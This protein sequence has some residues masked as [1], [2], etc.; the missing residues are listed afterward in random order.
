MSKPKP[1]LGKGLVR[2][3][4]QTT[5]SHSSISGQSAP[6][7][8]QL[9]P[10]VSHHPQSQLYST[11]T[12]EVSP[13]FPLPSYSTPSHSLSPIVSRAGPSTWSLPAA[14]SGLVIQP[15]PYLSLLPTWD[16][17]SSEASSSRH[18][19]NSNPIIQP[20]RLSPSLKALRTPKPTRVHRA[21][22]TTSSAPARA[23]VEMSSMSIFSSSFLGPLPPGPSLPPSLLS[24][25]IQT[26]QAGY[27]LTLPPPIPP[28][29]KPSR[30]DESHH[31]VLSPAPTPL[32]PSI[33]SSIT[34]H[35]HLAFPDP[36]RPTTLPSLT[37]SADG[38]GLNLY[39]S[40][41]IFHLGASGLAKERTPPPPPRRDR[42]P[43]PPPRP[44]SFPLPEITPP[45]TLHST[46]VGEDAYFARLDGMCIA[47]GVGGWARSGRGGADAGRWSRLLTHFCEVEVGDWWAGAEDYL[48]QVGK[49]GGEDGTGGGKSLRGE[50]KGMSGW[51]R[52]AWSAGR[53]EDKEGHGDGLEG[54]R[55]RKPLDPVEIM[56]KGFEKCLACVMAEVSEREG[57]RSMSLS[58]LAFVLRPAMFPIPFLCPSRSFHR[59]L[60][61]PSFPSSYSTFYPSALLPLRTSSP[62]SFSSSF[63]ATSATPRSADAS[64]RRG[65]TAP[66]PAS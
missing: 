54:G 34:S 23:A 7:G 37:E 22:Y 46:G 13:A 56:Q 18:D 65:S 3:L 51:A 39:S 33:S 15:S 28:S 53:G 2:T 5:H 24:F 50:G 30:S 16:P 55:R 57:S 8:L 49:V 27:D 45:T 62:P 47:D 52:R 32:D 41:L 35:P 4:A 64:P 43:T 31:T 14:L 63:S 48:D 59:I 26:G 1:G 38:T 36:A 21:S 61:H 17:P 44:R 42:S 60:P 12:R 40:N 29:P 9:A 25:P 20:Y 58:S 11:S 10:V 19:S 66:R 6:H